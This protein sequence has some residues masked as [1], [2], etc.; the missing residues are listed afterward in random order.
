MTIVINY[1]RKSG[2]MPD[3]LT[4]VKSY[5]NTSVWSVDVEFNN[6]K[7]EPFYAVESVKELS[8]PDV[9]IYELSV[10]FIN[11]DTGR[12][13]TIHLAFSKSI[14]KLKQKAID[15]NKNIYDQ[16]WIQRENFIELNLGDDYY[17]DS[18]IIKQITLI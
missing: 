12:Y 2:R 13:D 5:K 17:K 6:G 4:D 3:T 18:Y 15:T 8:E 11:D 16:Q 9:V 14:D 1:T 10:V 7:I